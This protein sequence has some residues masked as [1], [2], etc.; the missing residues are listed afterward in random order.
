MVDIDH[1]VTVP[2][3]LQN[4]NINWIFLSWLLVLFQSDG[5]SQDCEREHEMEGVRC[6]GE[7]IKEVSEAAEDDKGAE[8]EEDSSKGED[9]GAGDEVEELERDRE[10]GEGDEEV[11]R[12]LALEDVV[13]GPESLGFFVY[14]DAAKEGEGRR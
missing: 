3:N 8:L 12:F 13:E 7:D 9:G 5:C 2:F 11:A 4:P 14:A 6:V 1:S 10:V